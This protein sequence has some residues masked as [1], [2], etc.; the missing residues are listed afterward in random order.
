MVR[1]QQ[2]PELWQ[3]Y[4]F[5]LERVDENEGGIVLPCELLRPAERYASIRRE[6][7]RGDDGP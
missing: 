6:V 1:P 4:G 5:G 7:S 3:S 2:S